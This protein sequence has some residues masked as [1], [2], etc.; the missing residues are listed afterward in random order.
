MT[1]PAAKRPDGV[2][3]V[4][5]AQRSRAVR[6]LAPGMLLA[7]AGHALILAGQPW[8]LALGAMSVGSALIAVWGLPRTLPAPWAGRPGTGDNP[9][10]GRAHR[11]RRESGAGLSR[12]SEAG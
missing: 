4:L 3:R 12:G 6:L 2:L 10:A 7:L 11:E 1:G 8:R 5:T 9:D